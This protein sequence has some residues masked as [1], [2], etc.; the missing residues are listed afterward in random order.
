MWTSG[1][2]DLNFGDYTDP[3]T[4]RDG[5]RQYGYNTNVKI[6]LGEEAI[7][8]GVQIINKVDQKDFYENYKIMKLQFS[9]GYSKEIELAN[10]KQNDVSKLDSPIKTS[11]VGVLGIST[12]G[13]VPDD[14]GYWLTWGDG[15]T[16][17]RSGLSEIRLF[18]CGGGS[19][20]IFTFQRF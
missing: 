9:N 13:K 1:L 18:G 2:N 3:R 10:G 6:I 5:L 17:W 15:S 7:V 19:F 4:K 20:N 11:F 14:F 8:T 12:W 16:G